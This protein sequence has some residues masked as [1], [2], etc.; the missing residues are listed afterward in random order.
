MILY[1]TLLIKKTPQQSTPKLYAQPVWESLSIGNYEEKVRATE[2]AFLRGL[3]MCTVNERK[4]GGRRMEDVKRLTDPSKKQMKK[5]RNSSLLSSYLISNNKHVCHSN[6]GNISKEHMNQKDKSLEQVEGHMNE[7][8]DGTCAGLQKVS[9]QM[10]LEM[11]P[12]SKGKLNSRLDF[13][14]PVIFFPLILH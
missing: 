6:K 5:K 13:C 3:R 4:I 14:L 8:Q 10:W 9:G 1:F 7:T 11:I 2:G 12:P